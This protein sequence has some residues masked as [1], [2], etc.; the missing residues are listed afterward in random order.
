MHRHFVLESQQIQVCVTSAFR[1]MNNTAQL[2]PVYKQD[3]P[4]MENAPVSVEW[5]TVWI[6]VSS[7]LILTPAQS[8]SLS[9]LV[10]NTVSGLLFSPKVFDFS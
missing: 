9:P 7:E 10:T 1:I 8:T 2:D 4:S 3:K 5:W 6:H